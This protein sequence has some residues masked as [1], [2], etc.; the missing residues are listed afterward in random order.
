MSLFATWKT[1]NAWKCEIQVARKSEWWHNQRSVVRWYFFCDNGCLEWSI[2]VTPFKLPSDRKGIRFLEW[3]ESMRKYLECTVSILK[4]R[5]R[6]LKAGIRVHYIKTADA[7]FKTHYTLH[8]YLLDADWRD[9]PWES[10]VSCDYDDNSFQFFEGNLIP[11][12]VH[13]L[14]KDYEL[15]YEICL[16]RVGINNP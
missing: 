11:A 9:S 12:T 5:W 3:L 10:S 13:E 6:I 2:L 14:Y 8:N 4:Q 7:I 15:L 16:S 1:V